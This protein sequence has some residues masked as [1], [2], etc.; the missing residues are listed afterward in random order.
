[1]SR[2]DGDC[3][4]YKDLPTGLLHPPLKDRR[5]WWVQVLLASVLLVHLG[6]GITGDLGK[7]S[8]PGFVSILFMFVPIIYAGSSF[9]LRGSVAVA[10]EGVVLSIPQEM[11]LPHSA[12]QLWGAWSVLAMVLV[13]AV[14]LGERFDKERKHH[15]VQLAAKQVEA[16]QLFEHAFADNIAGML[17]TDLDHRV[18]AV[19]DSFC[20][21][22]G[23]TSE[24]LLGRD[25]GW[26]TFPDDQGIAKSVSAQMLADGKSIYIKRYQHKDG[27]I[28]WAEVS[29]SLA[30]DE[31]GRPQYFIGS[32]RDITEERSLLAQLYHQALHD[33]LLDLRTVLCSRTASLRRW[34]GF[35]ARTNGW[36][37]F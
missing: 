10:L 8:I 9:G 14:L 19:N 37:C 6:F 24:D 2:H 31:T 3:Q 26:V 15:A 7:I 17:L 35:P 1:M 29:K 33:P 22:L 12:T 20:K 36:R 28:V 13:V 16:Q 30:H 23:R 27:Q 18:L 25:S 11:F 34:L 4:R 32:V 21:M 5:F